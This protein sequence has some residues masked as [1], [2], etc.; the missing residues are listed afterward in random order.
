MHREADAEA[1]VQ[2]EFRQMTA[3]KLKHRLSWNASSVALPPSSA[4]RE[5]GW[6]PREP[7]SDTSRHD[8]HHGNI[9]FVNPPTLYYLS[10]PPP[11]TGV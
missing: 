2:A 3:I 8:R 1:T 11:K 10:T 6:R 9:L 5:L 4:N 7:P